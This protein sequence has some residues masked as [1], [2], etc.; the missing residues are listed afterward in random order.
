MGVRYR[1]SYAVGLWTSTAVVEEHC[2]CQGG[3][4]GGAQC[5]A[6]R[7]ARATKRA[8]VAVSGSA[9][10]TEADLDARHLVRARDGEPDPARGQISTS[11]PAR[12][13]ST[14]TSRCWGPGKNPELVDV[15][16][17][18]SRSENVDDRVAALEIAGL[19]CEIVDVEAYAMENACT[20]LIDQWPNG[21]H[22]HTIAVADIGATTTT[23]NV[24]HNNHIIYT[25]E[26]NFGGRQLTGRSSAATACRVE[27]RAWLRRG[28][29]RTTI[30]PGLSSRSEA[31]AQQ[32][33][34]SIPVFYSA[35]PSTTSTSWCQCGGNIPGMMT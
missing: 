33:N 7:P 9:V 1:V 17:A 20:Q 27:G 22:D 34:R 25:R 13:R 15:L 19:T 14:S 31:M 8:A 18:A 11:R 30:S 2:G 5:R 35:V 26:Q 10:I 23:L 6:A 28:G 4:Q 21:G 3:R 24:L 32:V 12:K 29:L 16:L